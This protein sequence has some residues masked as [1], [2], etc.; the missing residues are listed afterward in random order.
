MYFIEEQLMPFDEQMSE[1]D[2]AEQ[3]ALRRD[4]IVELS[5]YLEALQEDVNATKETIDDLV[6][7]LEDDYGVKTDER[8]Y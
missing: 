8:F 7:E 6:Q 2:K 3:I 1:D 4:Y 5:Y